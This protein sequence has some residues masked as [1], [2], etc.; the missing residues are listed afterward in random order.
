MR[1]LIACGILLAIIVPVCIVC[2][3]T[4]K[5]HTEQLAV[6]METAAGYADA[7]DFDA[8][9]KELAIVSQLWKKDKM[10]LVVYIERS[11]VDDVDEQIEYIKALAARENEEFSPQAQVCAFLIRKIYQ[12]EKITAKSIL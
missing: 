4:A 1:R 11:E 9:V 12:N 5:R 2:I 10:I 7:G 3:R 8:A 6:H